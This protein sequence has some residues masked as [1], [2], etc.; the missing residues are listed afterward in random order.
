MLFARRVC[1][2]FSVWDVL[3]VERRLPAATGWGFR[4][5]YEVWPPLP[6][7]RYGC[8]ARRGGI[9]VVV[10]VELGY[11]VD[12]MAVCGLYPAGKGIRYGV[13]VLGGSGR[14]FL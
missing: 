12:I 10:C 1:S 3:S 14:V 13:V 4:A 8:P 7:R 2:H 6:S 9:V 11:E 5:A